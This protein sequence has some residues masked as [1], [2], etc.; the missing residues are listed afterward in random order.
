MKAFYRITGLIC[1]VYGIVILGILGMGGV[2][3]FFFLAAGLFLMALSLL[4]D[5]MPVTLKRGVTALTVVLGMMFLI[6]EGI[7]IHDAVSPASEN[8]DYVIVLGA[9]VR[10]DGPTV[11]F[12]ARIEAGYRYAHDNERVMIITTGGKGDDEHMAEALVARNYLMNM[13]IP[14]ARILYEDRSTNTQENIENS[15][16]LIEG[17]G[18]DPETAKIIIVSASYHLC[19]A[20]FI[21]DR[22]GFR[23]VE[24]LGSNG[25]M[26]LMPHYYTREFFA[27]IKDFVDLTFFENQTVLN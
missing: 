18:D 4:W 8:A 24:T 27:L 2:F 1:A 26:I 6:I 15:R 13:G 22:M 14:E 25:L 20:R 10:K 19:R 16:M 17:R 12:K 21:A 9:R 3:N 11:D 7:I 5:R 23:N